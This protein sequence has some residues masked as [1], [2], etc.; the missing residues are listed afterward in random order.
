MTRGRLFSHLELQQRR[1]RLLEELGLPED[2]VY[3]LANTY[4]LRPEERAMFREVEAC[5]YLLAAEDL[6]S[7]DHREC[8]AAA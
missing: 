4:S 1:S 3:E 5:D 2:R 6:Q 8:S 7:Q